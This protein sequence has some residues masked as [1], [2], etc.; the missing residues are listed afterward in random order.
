MFD[1][2]IVS[3]LDTMSYDA[4]KPNEQLDF[5]MNLTKGNHVI[6]IFGASRVDYMTSWYFQVDSSVWYS[7]TLK[8]LNRYRVMKQ[9][10]GKT[11]IWFGKVTVDQDSRT[12]WHTVSVNGTFNN[13]VVVMGPLSSNG[14]HPAVPR[15]KN[16]R[17][18][19]IG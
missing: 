1:G 14:K 3:Q 9:I 5:C 13:P 18:N 16:V 15:V 4:K 19:S 10:Q 7:W 6:E 8:N 17:R 12:Q 2:K 11:T